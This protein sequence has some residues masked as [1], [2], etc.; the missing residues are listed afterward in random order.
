[1]RA[2]P[3]LRSLVTF[4]HLNLNDEI[5]PLDAE[6]QFELV[7]CRNVLM[8]FEVGRRERVL[9][10]ILTRLPPR[11]YLFLGDA[12]GLNGFEGLRLAAPSVHTFKANVPAGRLASDE[13]AG[14][15]AR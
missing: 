6:A 15:G 13:P 11:G 10:R 12:E 9:R 1:M 14:T 7:F 4:R 5:W 3:E 8:Y 2:G